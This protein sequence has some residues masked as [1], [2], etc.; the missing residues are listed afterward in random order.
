MQRPF[1]P[2]LCALRENKIVRGIESK[3]DNIYTVGAGSLHMYFPF[4]FLMQPRCVCH[5]PKGI[6]AS[7]Y[8]LCMS[9]LYFS[10]KNRILLPTL[11]LREKEEF[12]FL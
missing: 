3:V 4:T 6:L 12:T 10:H 5:L 11:S 1:P 9:V 8:L 2:L 7:S